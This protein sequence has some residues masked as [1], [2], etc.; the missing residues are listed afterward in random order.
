MRSTQ[1]KQY[2]PV[3]FSALRSPAIFEYVIPA[4][5][6][7]WFSYMVAGS[8]IGEDGW[9]LYS[10]SKEQEY[11]ELLE[12]A[13]RRVLEKLRSGEWIADGICASHGPQ[14]IKIEPALWSY[15]GFDSRAVEAHGEGF[16][17]IALS[18]S[19]TEPPKPPLPYIASGKLRP[20][21]IKWIRSYVEQFSS[22]PLRDDVLAAARDAFDVEISDNMYRE[23]RSAA[24]LE[25]HH[26]QRGAPIKKVKG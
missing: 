15:L 20:Q 11:D 25:P 10:R 17:F 7:R 16:R 6:W 13:V 22:P 21:L 1:L 8:L 23:C 12:E 19:S 3:M 5:E 2:V 14:L 26:I 18:F 9:P 4:K 24:G